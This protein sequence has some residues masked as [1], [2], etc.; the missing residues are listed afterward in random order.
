MD[1]AGAL[2]KVVQTIGRLREVSI[3]AG[4][5]G[6]K[7]ADLTD[8][9]AELQSRLRAEL[10]QSTQ[11]LRAVE[12]STRQLQLET[13]QQLGALTEAL[14]RALAEERP[15][16]SLLAQLRHDYLQHL[17]RLQQL[18]Q[19]QLPLLLTDMGRAGQSVSATL[20]SIQ[21]LTLQSTVE[22]QRLRAGS[23][24]QRQALLDMRIGLDKQT[25]SID[26]QTE[27]FTESLLHLWK[28]LE[29]HF[30]GARQETQQRFELL[31]SEA[32][33]VQQNADEQFQQLWNQQLAEQI[34]A[35]AAHLEATLVG[36]RE[37]AQPTRR[38][39]DSE[40]LTGVQKVRE[41]FDPLQKVEKVFRAAHGLE[42][43]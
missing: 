6:K 13:D 7:A 16:R 29:V 20:A 10:D 39:A 25:E 1:D 4:Q 3:A 36:L 5:Q 9:L 19:E 27:Q 38:L 11:S 31:L 32:K 18:T 22:C 2:S 15:S 41:S 42:L 8:Q 12:E 24:Q 14:E 17:Q 43:C 35:L 26:Q 28:N 21:S 30:S 34:Q 33:K 23:A 40:V 37:M